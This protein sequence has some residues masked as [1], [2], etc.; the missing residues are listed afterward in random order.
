MKGLHHIPRRRL[1][2]P[3]PYFVFVSPLITLHP[4]LF[5]TFARAFI[6]FA[7]VRL[8]KIAIFWEFFLDAEK[9]KNAKYVNV[10]NKIH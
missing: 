4:L 9:P 6:L 10:L 2:P 3:L 8:Q 7:C 1:Y 5:T